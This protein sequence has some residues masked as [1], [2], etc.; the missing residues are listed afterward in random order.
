[1]RHGDYRPFD[2]LV[3]RDLAPLTI[4]R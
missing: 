4:S 3:S 1:M 2:I